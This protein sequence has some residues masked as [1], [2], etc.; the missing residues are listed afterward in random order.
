MNSSREI[1]LTVVLVSGEFELSE[2]A[3]LGF[4]S[5]NK[6]KKPVKSLVQTSFAE[7]L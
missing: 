2:F 3:I 6:G 7:K 1:G 5:T 4:Y